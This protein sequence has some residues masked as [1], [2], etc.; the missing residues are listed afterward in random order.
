M[1]FLAISKGRGREKMLRHLG[2][3]VSYYQLIGDT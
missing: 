1:T 3:E 2:R